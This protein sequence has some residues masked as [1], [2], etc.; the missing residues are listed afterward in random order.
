MHCYSIHWGPVVVAS[1][2]L[3]SA[4]NDRLYCP[5]GG[6]I[7]SDGPFDLFS[8]DYD[9]PPSSQRSPPRRLESER[10]ATIPTCILTSP[11]RPR[12]DP[13]FQTAPRDRQA[14]S[15]IL[16]PLPIVS[17]AQK[18]PRGRPRGSRNRPKTHAGNLSDSS[19][20][21]K[22]SVALPQPPATAGQQKHLRDSVGR[23]KRVISHCNQC[24]LQFNSLY[25]LRR[26]VTREHR[27]GTLTAHCDQC[28]KTLVDRYSLKRHMATCSSDKRPYPCGIC[29]SSFKTD[30]TRLKHIEAV[31]SPPPL[32][33]HSS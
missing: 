24:D 12:K 18:R 10:E 16:Q 20:W 25:A 15:S 23:A 32:I 28:G 19:K 29:G 33:R 6:V 1:L 4:H 31:H 27:G 7:S 17:P 9:A 22:E 3:C 13:I 5:V 2:R 30:Y 14:E 8:M 26:H 21:S 11:V